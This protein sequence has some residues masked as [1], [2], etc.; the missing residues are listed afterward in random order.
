M[1]RDPEL[2]VPEWEEVAAVACAVQ[3]MWLA[4]TSLKIGAYWSSPSTID[5]PVFKEFVKLHSGERC[6]GLFYMG[7]Y[8]EAPQQG[9]RTPIASKVEWLNK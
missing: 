5:S 3:N 9:K 4:C 2:S 8:D 7:Y 1:Q 6:L